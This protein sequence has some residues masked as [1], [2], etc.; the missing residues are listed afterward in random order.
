MKYLIHIGA[1]IILYTSMYVNGEDEGI[2]NIVS[3]AV[4][5]DM[6]RADDKIRCLLNGYD[7]LNE[8]KCKL[9]PGSLDTYTCYCS[10]GM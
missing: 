8:G 3:D 4:E 10:A 6:D 1:C 2:S 9:S 5:S 7:C